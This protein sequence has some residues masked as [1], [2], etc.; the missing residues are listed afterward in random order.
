MTEL[1]PAQEKRK[2]FPLF[3]SPQSHLASPQKRKGGKGEKNRGII[4]WKPNFT[5]NLQGCKHAP[6]IM[7]LPSKNLFFFLKN[8][9][10]GE[11]TNI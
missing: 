5:D 2:Q 6:M 7:S 1:N 9:G 10:G 11:G 4:E 3:S 8:K